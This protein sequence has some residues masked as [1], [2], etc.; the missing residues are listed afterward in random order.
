MVDRCLVDGKSPAAIMEM[1]GRPQSEI[2]YTCIT[3]PDA[4]PDDINGA[5]IGP[6]MGFGQCTSSSGL[7]APDKV[8]SG[9]NLSS[10]PAPNVSYNGTG[11]AGAGGAGGAGG[12]GIGKIALAGGA[13]VVLIVILSI[14]GIPS[15][16]LGAG[17][18]LSLILSYILTDD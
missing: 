2:Q 15:L 9:G 1:H 14:V 8:G 17:A 5:Q 13:L 12:L 16:A 3:T 6:G 10:L 18:L 11:V 4:G 7:S